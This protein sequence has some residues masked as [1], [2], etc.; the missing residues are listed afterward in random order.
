MLLKENTMKTDLETRE[1]LL[2][3]AKTEFIE[4]GYL[5]ASLRNICKNAQVTTGALY[6][7]FENK[8]DLF[9]SLVEVPLKELQ[10]II[11][12]YFDRERAQ[13]DGYIREKNGYAVHYEIAKEV[14]HCLYQNYD[15][16]FLLVTRSQGSRF[17]HFTDEIVEMMEKHYRTMADEIALQRESVRLD[18]YMIHWLTHTKVDF[19]IHMIT[20]EKSEQMAV[21]HMESIIKCMAAGWNEL[22]KG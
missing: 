12:Q 8:E 20:H 13:I 18:D 6:F 4:K 9:S 22:L 2:V 14:L 21:K 15:A 19:Y 3:N 5:Q 1:R 17:E 11:R 10:G 7:F 16:F